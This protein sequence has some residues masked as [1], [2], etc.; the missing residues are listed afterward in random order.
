MSKYFEKCAVMPC[1]SANKRFNY[2]CD[3]KVIK[4]VK[5]LND[6]SVTRS[7][8]LPIAGYKVSSIVVQ[9][10]RMAGLISRAFRCRDR[11][12]L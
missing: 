9:A 4:V 1:G 7:Q 10:N 6:L 3:G 5:E 8:K 12:V 2:T 11:K